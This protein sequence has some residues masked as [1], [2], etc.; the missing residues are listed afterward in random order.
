MSSVSSFGPLDAGAGSPDAVSAH[1]RALFGYEVVGFIGEGAGSAIYCVSDPA[2]GQIYALKHVTRKT[3]KDL[4]FIE[5]L[6]AE[7][8]VGR[9]IAHP[10]LRRIIDFKVNRTMLF[11]VVEA[12]LVM[13]LFDGYTLERELPR[14]NADLL[15]IFVQTAR[16][17]KAMHAAGFV[18][19]D[20]KPNNILFNNRFEVKVIDLGQACRIGT[21]K[22]R[23][24]G[25]P[26]YIAPEQVKCKPLSVQ[27]DVF[28]LGATMY[29]CLTGRKIPTLYTAGK[30]ENAIVTDELIPMP[31]QLNPVI[32]EGLSNFVME[33]VRLNPAKRPAEMGE[34]ATR[35]ELFHHLLAQRE[36]RPA[37]A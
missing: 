18:H 15:S 35:L 14:S 26:D 12:A 31:S 6:E 21:A 11:K 23:I 32:P 2:S 9:M 33:C 34:V 24:Q 4:R 19:C 22:A 36:G 1:P 37:V 28:N 13:E 10:N 16:A 7:Y 20:L 8:E 27:T 3:D 5:Q 29:W 25:T 30:G 17:L